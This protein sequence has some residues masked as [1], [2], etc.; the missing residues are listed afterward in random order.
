M[1][2]ARAFWTFQ[3]RLSKIPSPVHLSCVDKKDADPN[4]HPPSPLGLESSEANR[5]RRR[6]NS[7]QSAVFGE[8]G[9]GTVMG[10]SELVQAP[11][12]EPGK[13]VDLGHYCFCNLFNEQ[14]WCKL[15]YGRT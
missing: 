2:S 10:I 15:V 3:K 14:C 6:K 1:K 12:F 9:K 8:A 11:T 5:G 7:R 13:K 4:P